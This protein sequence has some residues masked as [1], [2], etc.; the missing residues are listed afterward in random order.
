MLWLE[1]AVSEIVEQHHAAARESRPERLERG[2]LGCRG[3]HVEMEIGDCLRLDLVERG[4]NG[5]DDDAHVLPGGEGPLRSVDALD[6]AG[7]GPFRATLNMLALCRRQNGLVDTRER[8]EQPER[9]AERVPVEQLHDR[10]AEEPA[11]DPAL[12]EV[13]IETSGARR[14]PQADVDAPLPVIVLARSHDATG[15]R[16]RE[17]RIADEVVIV[18]RRQTVGPIDAR[19]IRHELVSTRFDHPGHEVASA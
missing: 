1:S 12:D 2:Y 14:R 4:R 5:A 6:V 3:V 8:V 17:V 10:R 11:I 9:L 15:V 18:D 7:S 16:P 13:A 19:I